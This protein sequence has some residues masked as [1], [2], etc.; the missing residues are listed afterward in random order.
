MMYILGLLHVLLIL[1]PK[2]HPEIAGRGVEYAWGYSKLR[3]RRDF[4]DAIAKNIKQS[5][6]KLLDRSVLITNRIRKF[7][8]KAR[9]YKLI[10]ALIFHLADSKDTSTGKDEIEHITKAFKAHRLAMNSDYAFIANA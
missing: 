2:C 7:V 5:V 1:T 8:R 3:F 6:L 4:N 9:E 10:Y